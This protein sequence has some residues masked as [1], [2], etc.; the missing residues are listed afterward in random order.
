[1]K[2]P[3][4]NGKGDLPDNAYIH[5]L[6]ESM[7]KASPPFSK[8]KELAK[9]RQETCQRLNTEGYSIREIMRLL[10]YKSPRSVVVNIRGPRK[11]RRRDEPDRQAVVEAAKDALF[12]LEA[13]DALPIILDTEGHAYKR[14]DCRS[15][16]DPGTQIQELINRLKAAPAQEAVVEIMATAILTANRIINVGAYLTH[17]EAQEWE[18][19]VK[20]ALRQEAVVGGC[21][22]C[23]WDGDRFTY[24]CRFCIRM[25]HEP[26]TDK[27]EPAMRQ[28]EE[29]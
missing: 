14:I 19:G 17:L 28:E 12:G 22:G 8:R 27:Y 20:A 13:I 10:G 4:C 7:A 9:W 25:H 5:R 18:R 23:K 6:A 21:E 24:V 15:I 11:V 3:I 1:M 2:C 29:K 26:V 16:F